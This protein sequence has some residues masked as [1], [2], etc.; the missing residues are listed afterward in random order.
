MFNAHEEQDIMRKICFRG[1]VRR[2]NDSHCSHSLDKVTWVF[3]DLEVHRGDNRVIIHTY[4]DDGSY[5]RQF[6]VV[7]ST[8]GQY[9]GMKDKNDVEIYEGD[10][11]SSITDDESDMGR[12]EYNEDFGKYIVVYNEYSGNWFDFEGTKGE[13]IA[14]S[15]EVLGNIHDNPEMI[16]G[17]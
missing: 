2:L 17:L 16:E 14:H 6:D 5:Y 9:T 15:C 10:I 3:G 8:V 13:F 12:V 4:H 11:L 7:P 1:K